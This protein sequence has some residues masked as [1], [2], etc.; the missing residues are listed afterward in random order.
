MKTCARCGLASPDTAARCDCGFNFVSGDAAGE[1]RRSRRNGWLCTIGGG[2]L[3]V[4]GVFES[5]GVIPM[6]SIAVLTLDTHQVDLGALI[7]GALLA[8]RGIQ[9]LDRSPVSARKAG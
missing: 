9:I 1:V 5:L 6:V 7:L 3:F 4:F 2:V 8:G